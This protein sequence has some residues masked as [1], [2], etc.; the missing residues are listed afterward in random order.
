MALWTLFLCFLI[1]F[2][3]SH[4]V[5]WLF[6]L[7]IDRSWWV[8]NLQLTM[9]AVA[10]DWLMQIRITHNLINIGI[11]LAIRKPWF[12][13]LFLAIDRWLV[14]LLWNAN[15]WDLVYLSFITTLYSQILSW[16]MSVPIRSSSFDTLIFA[17][18][19]NSLIFQV[20]FCSLSFWFLIFT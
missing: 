14:M 3:G 4:Q 9:K 7:A 11:L 8:T 15:R 1:V 5:I 19:F 2:D 16:S 18:H 10:F 12:T 6:V 17:L 20:I 13:G